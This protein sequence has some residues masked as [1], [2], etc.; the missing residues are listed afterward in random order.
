VDEFGWLETVLGVSFN[1]LMLLVGRLEQRPGSTASYPQRSFCEGL[2]QP[3][4]GLM[5]PSVMLE[6][7]PG[8]TETESSSCSFGDGGSVSWSLSS[9]VPCERSV[10]SSEPEKDKKERKWRRRTTRNDE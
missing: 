3:G 1:A 4:V 9:V 2:T 5:Q 6:R 7:R 8:E 10:L